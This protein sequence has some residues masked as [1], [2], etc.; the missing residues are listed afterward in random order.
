M[1]RH[2]L[3]TLPPQ[4]SQ[5]KM[6]SNSINREG[7]YMP[8][9]CA[10]CLKALMNYDKTH[11]VGRGVKTHNEYFSYVPCSPGPFSC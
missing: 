8:N 3:L 2:A 7:T 11:I 9:A 5:S 1:L 10:P 6:L 4:N